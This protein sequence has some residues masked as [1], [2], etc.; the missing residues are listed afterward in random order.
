MAQKTIPSR[1]LRQAKAWQKEDQRGRYQVGML[2]V[3]VM[4]LNMP[5]AI[6]SAVYLV[7][8]ACLYEAERQHPGRFGLITCKSDQHDVFFRISSMVILRDEQSARPFC[9][10]LIIV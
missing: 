9:K 8:S 2:L 6:F 1:P 4:A 7:P 10:S 3:G 5:L